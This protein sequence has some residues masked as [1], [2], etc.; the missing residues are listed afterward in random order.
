MADGKVDPYG[1]FDEV[2]RI[3]E[4]LDKISGLID[5]ING[6]LRRERDALTSEIE[7]IGA[8]SGSVPLTSVGPSGI[9][10]EFQRE[11]REDTVR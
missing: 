7:S 11:T 5:G 10:G 8:R 4:T 9:G 6:A 1:G 3:C 2:R